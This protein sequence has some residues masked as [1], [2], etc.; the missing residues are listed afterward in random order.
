MESLRRHLLAGAFIAV[1]LLLGGIGLYKYHNGDISL[2]NIFGTPKKVTESEIVGMWRYVS[3]RGSKNYFLLGTEGLQFSIDRRS[4][5]HTFQ[6]YFNGGTSEGGTW[7]LDDTGKLK[8]SF[9]ISQVEYETEYF[10]NR[11]KTTATT[12]TLENTDQNVKFEY[13]YVSGE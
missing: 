4:D 11:V 12:L 13:A 8:I 7:T 6:T 1:I 3:S 5:S 10:F 9:N 2:E